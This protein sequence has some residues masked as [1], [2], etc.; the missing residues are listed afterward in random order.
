MNIISRKAEIFSED[1]SAYYQDIYYYVKSKIR[2]SSIVD[3]LIQEIFIRYYNTFE[4][5]KNKKSWLYGIAKNVLSNHHRI[6]QTDHLPEELMLKKKSKLSADSNINYIILKEAI[7][8]I[9]DCSDK[10]V[11]E[12]IVFMGYSQKETG[13]LLNYPQHNVKYRFQRALK[14]VRN[15]LHTKGINEISD[16]L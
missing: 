16:L 6:K 4:T 14:Q 13:S 10:T 7:A 12:H 9:K 15:Y 11:F 5:A 8:S 1:Y 3:D 2:D